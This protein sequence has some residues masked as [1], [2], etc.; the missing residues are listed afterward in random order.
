MP[1]S[2]DQNWQNGGCFSKISGTQKYIV[3][4]LVPPSSYDL[5][6]RTLNEVSKL[7]EHLSFHI[8]NTLILIWKKSQKGKKSF[9][10]KRRPVCSGIKVRLIPNDFSRRPTLLPKNKQT[11]STLLP[12]DLFLFIFWK[13]L[14]THYKINWPLTR[15][16][17]EFLLKLARK[18]C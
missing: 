11:N 10:P 5:N 17:L 7:A 1:E 12:V 4:I 16:L 18:K 3:L 9:L 15:P 8:K 6:L 14:K 2:F 13:K